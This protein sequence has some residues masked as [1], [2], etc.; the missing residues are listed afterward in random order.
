MMKVVLSTLLFLSIGI[1]TN[2][3]GQSYKTAVGFR[4]GLSSGVSVKHFIESDKAIE[5]LF[6]SRWSGVNITGLYEVEKSIDDIDGLSWFYGVGAHVGFWKSVNNLNWFDTSSGS[7]MVLGVDGIIGLDFTIPNAPINFQLDYK[8][9][10]NLL[11]H[12]GWWADEFAISVRFAL[13]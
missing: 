3:Y 12:Q 7:K 4:G 13:K 1:L 10:Y 6:S 2:T 9:A 8:P 11:G 5:G